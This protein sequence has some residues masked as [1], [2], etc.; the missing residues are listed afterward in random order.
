MR[1]QLN[2][3]T[4]TFATY[5]PSASVIAVAST[6]TKSV[7]L[8]DAK[9][10]EKPPFAS[11]DLDG[12]DSGRGR[13]GWSKLE[14]SNDGKSLLVATT[15][16]G[17]YVLDAFDGTLRHYCARPRQGTRSERRAPSETQSSRPVGQGD[18]CFSPDGKYLI[19]GSGADDGL[20]AWDVSGEGKGE[21]LQ[22]CAELP[23]SSGQAGGRCEVVGYNPKHNMLV[24]ADKEIL[25]WLPDPELAA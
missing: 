25:L 18:V 10:F 22:P 2:I 4:P 3:T 14:F 9:N 6:A 20:V 7:M 13:G 15:G 23:V 16:A 17:H 24:S 5:D 11:F 1:G 12:L 21:E 8:Y 19:G